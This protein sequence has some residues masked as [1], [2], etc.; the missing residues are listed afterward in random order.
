[1]ETER[2]RATLRGQTPCAK[3]RAVL[4]R[5]FGRASTSGAAVAQW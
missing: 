1:M 2:D 4:V 5:D 3:D